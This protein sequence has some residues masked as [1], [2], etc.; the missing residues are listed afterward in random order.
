MGNETFY[1]DGLNG[2]DFFK[3][4]FR[5]TIFR[6]RLDGLTE[7]GLCVAWTIFENKLNSFRKIIPLKI[8]SSKN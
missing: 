5:R 8:L 6:L 7:T 3:A 1:G 2:F 4:G